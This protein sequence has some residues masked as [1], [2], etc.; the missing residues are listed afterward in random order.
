MRFSGICPAITLYIQQHYTANFKSCKA[1]LMRNMA[2]MNHAV[3]YVDI[4]RKF[5]RLKLVYDNA[6]AS[7]Y[8]RHSF[9]YFE[10][11][12]P[13]ST[14]SLPTSPKATRSKRSFR[15]ASRILDPG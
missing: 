14:P 13:E 3:R 1:L 6:Y 9:V 7:C 4:L 11:D 5:F 15:R 2:I 10:M 12:D 8:S